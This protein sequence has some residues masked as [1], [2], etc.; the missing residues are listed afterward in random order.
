M[1]IKTIFKCISIAP[2]ADNKTS[3][4]DG[5]RQIKRYDKDT[6]CLIRDCNSCE[7]RATC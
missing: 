1:S 4:I 2:V 5:R 3:L 6:K 7:L